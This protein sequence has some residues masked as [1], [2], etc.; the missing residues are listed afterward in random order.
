MT[1]DGFLDG[2]RMGASH[3]KDQPITGLEGWNFESSRPQ[4]GLGLKNEFHEV[5]II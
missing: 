2:N 5:E 3:K 4:G 1:Q